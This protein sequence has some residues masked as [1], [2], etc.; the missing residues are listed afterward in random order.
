VNRLGIDFKSFLQVVKEFIKALGQIRTYSIH[1]NWYCFFGILWGIPIPIVTI[2]IDLYSTSLT[3]TILNIIGIINT[4]PFHFFFLLHPIL[5]GIVF[6]AMGTVRYNKEQKIEEFEKNLIDKNTKLE[7]ANRRL[8]EV[9][10][11]KSNFLSMVSHEL[12]TPLTTIQGYITFLNTEKPGILNPA[13]KECLKI[14]EETVVLLN[15]LIEE[16]LDLSKIE[17]GEF[18]VTLENTNM[19]EVFNKAIASLQFSARSKGVTLENNLPSKLPLVLADKQRILQLA[20]NLIENAI[21]FNQEG[22]KVYISASTQ[23]QNERVVF[24]IFDTGIG[25]PEDKLDKIFDKF[26]Q[27]DSSGKRKYGGCGLGLA[28]SKSIIEL[29]GGRIWVE[30]K[31]GKGSKFFFELLEQ[32]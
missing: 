25:I 10:K 16:L 24:C 30:S 15:N 29:H 11:L 5:F 4:H 9:D 14:S 1:K 6:G 31:V 12:R 17:T 32:K 23:N 8:R 27:V 21:K 13:Q 2:G 7:S 19:I 22:G 28:I 20:T 3:P 18:K 26:Y